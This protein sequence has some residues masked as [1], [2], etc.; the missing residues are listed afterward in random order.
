[1][2]LLVFPGHPPIIIFIEITWWVAAL[3]S[4]IIGM[5]EFLLAGRGGFS[6]SLGFSVELHSFFMD[7]RRMKW[8]LEDG[9]L[10]LYA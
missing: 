10:E 8:C 7:D 5:L 2:S 1:M 6:G 9:M 4:F 3:A